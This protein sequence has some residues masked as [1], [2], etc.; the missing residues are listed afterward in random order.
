MLRVSAASAS[1][2]AATATGDPSSSLPPAPSAPGPHG[3][4]ATPGL[5]PQV[6]VSDHGL[7]L[8][9]AK[10][11]VERDGRDVAAANTNLRIGQ[12]KQGGSLLDK[13]WPPS[14]SLIVAALVVAGGWGY[15]QW[16][17]QKE[18]EAEDRHQHLQAHLLHRVERQ[19]AS[20]PARGLLR[21]EIQE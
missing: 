14:P 19:D 16:E 18:A 2:R 13:V 6:D 17:E 10:R 12:G 21:L 8:A 15:L 11:S 20:G 4:F 1:A 3:A 7:E 5:A 9:R